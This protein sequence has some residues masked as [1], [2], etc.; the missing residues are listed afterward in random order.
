MSETKKRNTHLR[1]FKVKVGLEAVRGV[2][3]VHQIA[4][5]FGVHAVQTGQC[6]LAGV[7]RGTVYAQR[8]PNSPDAGIAIPKCSIA[9][10]ARSSPATATAF[11][12]SG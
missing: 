3:T 1:E 9:I 8:K 11:R 5:E 7:V 2:K 6:V 10:R 12:K 4:Q